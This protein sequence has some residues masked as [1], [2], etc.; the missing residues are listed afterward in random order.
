VLGGDFG[1]VDLGDAKA[2]AGVEQLVLPDGA[3]MRGRARCCMVVV[4]GGGMCARRLSGCRLAVLETSCPWWPSF[5]S[6]LWL[7]VCNPRH[8]TGNKICV[9]VASIPGRALSCHY[10][11][12]GGIFLTTSGLAG[13]V[14]VGYV[15]HLLLT[16]AV[17][18]EV[19]LRRPGPGS[20]GLRK[21][22]RLSL[23]FDLSLM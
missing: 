21:V 6:N 2:D 10:H 13:E 17:P 5:S 14:L 9:V 4:V 18:S 23:R 1:G 19:W 16:V 7:G 8:E 22:L 15:V 20:A 3:G 11:G 12:P